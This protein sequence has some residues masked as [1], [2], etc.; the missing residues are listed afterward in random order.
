M[1]LSC[2]NG[3]WASA[4][5]DSA[6]AVEE[7]AAEAEHTLPRYADHTYHDFSTY[8]EDGGRIEKHKKSDRNFP[9]RLHAILSDEQYSHIIAW[10][11]HGRAW[12][13]LN[14]KLLVDEVIPEFFGQ[15]KFA[16]FTRQLS[17]WGFKRLHQTGPDFGCYY[18]ECFL[19]GHPRLTVLMRRISPGRGKA[20]PNMHSEPDFYSIAKQFPLHATGEKP[21]FLPKS[22]GRRKL[23][24]KSLPTA[25]E[26]AASQVTSFDPLPV[27]SHNDLE[28]L[29]VMTSA[30]HSV[31]QF[32]VNNGNQYFGKAQGKTGQ[33][34]NTAPAPMFSD[35][36][37]AG[38]IGNL[39]QNV[40]T[41]GQAAASICMEDGLCSTDGTSSCHR[42]NSHNHQHSVGHKAPYAYP[43]H[44]QSLY[45]DPS[46]FNRNNLGYGGMNIYSQQQ[47]YLNNVQQGQAQGQGQPAYC[48]SNSASSNSHPQRF[49]HNSW[50]DKAATEDSL[51]EMPMSIPEKGFDFNI[52]SLEE[53]FCN[54]PVETTTPFFG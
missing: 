9:A 1:N 27:S 32:H 25:K 20:T 23:K 41:Q 44:V 11:P 46:M 40:Q 17:G 51:K 34:Y 49:S 4:F 21:V 3:E 15:S 31:N 50:D 33:M 7:A 52:S 30:P 38:A 8:I 29:A 26:S 14:K 35:Q 45:H 6:T 18:H 13:V 28:P 5:F 53:S 36:Y 37:V 48:S 10:M 43:S 24:V 12:K 39:Y 19:R 54:S 2:N 16:S 47:P 42:R 22:E